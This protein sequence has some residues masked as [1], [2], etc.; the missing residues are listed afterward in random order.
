MSDEFDGPIV[1]EYQG[2]PML[3]LNPDSQYKFQFGLGKAKMILNNLDA[4]RRFVESD[5]KSAD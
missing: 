1:S 5:G 4:I 2:K 3:V